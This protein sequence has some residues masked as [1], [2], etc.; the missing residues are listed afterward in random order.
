MTCKYDGW[1]EWP[2]RD[3]M[4]GDTTYSGPDGYKIYFEHGPDFFCPSSEGPICDCQNCV[5]VVS[6]A[7]EKD[8]VWEYEWDHYLRKVVSRLSESTVTND[9]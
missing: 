3:N 5:A 1:W 2:S 9:V 4:C 6:A 8:G 7:N